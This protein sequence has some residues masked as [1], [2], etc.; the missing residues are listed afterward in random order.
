M[1]GQ[2]LAALLIVL[3]LGCGPTRTAG[4]KGVAAKDLAVLSIAQLPAEAHVGIDTVQF[5]GAGDRYEIGKGREFYLPPGE[6]TGTFSFIAHVP[7]VGG[8]FVPRSALTLP[9]PK[10]VPLGTVTAGKTYELSLAPESFESLLQ[11]GRLSLVRE[12]AK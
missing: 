9:G 2:S 3:L 7:G 6:H 12:K 11:E 10:D 8:W 4:T 5:D 1:R